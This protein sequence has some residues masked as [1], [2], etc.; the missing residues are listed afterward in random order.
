M[1]GLGSM[2]LKYSGAGASQPDVEARPILLTR[3]NGK[4]VMISRVYRHYLLA[5]LGIIF[6]F[7]LTD[8]LTMGMAA[9]SIKNDLHLSDT[10]LGFVGGMAFFLFY[11][12][13]GVP[14]GRWA[15]RGNRVTILT[16]TRI[17]WSAFVML[18]GRTS[19]FVQLMIARMGAGVGEAGC[20]PPS[21][22]LIS[23]YFS[24]E[25][26]PQVLGLFFL[27]APLASLITYVGAGW[28]L[29]HYSWRV[30][31]TLVGMSGVF[32]APIAGVT[33]REPRRGLGR[34]RGARGGRF[35]G[36]N[37]AGLELVTADPHPPPLREAFRSLLRNVT[38]RNLLAAIVV[39][40]IF[41]AG[42]QQW[43]PAFFIRSYGLNSGTLGLWLALVYGVPGILGNI[44]GGRAASRWATSDERLQLAVIAIFNCSMSIVTP[45]VYLTRNYHTAFVLLAVINLAGGLGNGPVLAAMQLVVPSRLR[46]MS[47]MIA[48]FLA[49]LIGSGLG[50]IEVGAISDYLRPAF[51]E[52]SLRYALMI[53]GPWFFWAGW[54]VWRA[55]KAVAKDIDL[56]KGHAGPLN[57]MS[58]EQT[59]TL[60]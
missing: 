44:L 32:L 31:F 1:G 9:Q 48:Y 23:D 51:G 19:S 41:G 49:N 47:I 36:S 16:S 42:I 57:T 52:D 25:E 10:E 28:L 46:G 6:A 55:S 14:M 11:S 3:W 37:A 60:E 17:I 20:L 12:A 45:L 2:S 29:E 26:R 15:D 5:L 54:H 8:S 7:N 43:Q 13:F 40:Y 22:S 56:V 53:M 58:R 35:Q 21:Y 39:N 27:S 30:V 24:R 34:G 33:L 59:L 38:Y 18:T 50:P 4:A